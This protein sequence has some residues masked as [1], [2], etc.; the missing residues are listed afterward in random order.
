MPAW[1]FVVIPLE[2]WLDGQFSFYIRG[3]SATA[4]EQL[5]EA[6]GSDAR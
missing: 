4:P 2:A 3:A 1:R 6:S 5:S